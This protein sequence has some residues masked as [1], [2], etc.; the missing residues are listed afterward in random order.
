MSVR[1]LLHDM[2]GMHSACLF[3][4]LQKHAQL[5]IKPTLWRNVNGKDEPYYACLL[6]TSK[7]G[8]C[9]NNAT[10]MWK[11]EHWL[12]HNLKLCVTNLHVLQLL[13]LKHLCFIYL[14]L[15]TLKTFFNKKENQG[16]SSVCF[17]WIHTNLI[18]K[19]L[20]LP[21]RLKFLPTSW[22]SSDYYWYLTNYSCIKS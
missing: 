13:Q 19:N 4:R 7:A 22:F 8:L 18:L 16:W 11:H 12:L 3:K 5:Q 6:L 2:K 15:N 21:Q 10:P 20:M 14:I 1:F 9:L 17:I